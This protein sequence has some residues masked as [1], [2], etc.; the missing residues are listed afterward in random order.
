MEPCLK[1]SLVES[2]I[3]KIGWMLNILEMDGCSMAANHS[4]STLQFAPFCH[5][6][7]VDLRRARQVLCGHSLTRCDEEPPCRIFNGKSKKK[8]LFPNHRSNS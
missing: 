7:Y 3:F 8:L 2:R 4:S 1:I 6:C 5:K